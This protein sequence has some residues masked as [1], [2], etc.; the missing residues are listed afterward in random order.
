MYLLTIAVDF[1]LEVKKDYE[2]I[3]IVSERYIS[4][5]DIDAFLS[6]LIIGVEEIYDCANYS[7]G[8]FYHCFIGEVFQLEFLEYVTALC[9]Y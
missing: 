4:L 7:L 5:F 9:L 1:I 3:L 2:Y 6:D 8:L